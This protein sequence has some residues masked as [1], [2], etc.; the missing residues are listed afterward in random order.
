MAGIVHPKVWVLRYEASDDLDGVPKG[1]R[2]LRVLITSRNLTFDTSWDTVLRL[3]ESADSQGADLGAVGKLFL[4]LV[5][6][7]VD[8]IS[9]DH[10]ERVGFIGCNLAEGAVRAPGRR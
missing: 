7:T 10:L 5:S 4:G 6:N 2:R 8:T 3:D 1:D 9:N